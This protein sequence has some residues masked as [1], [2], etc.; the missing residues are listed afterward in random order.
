MRAIP[1]IIRSVSGRLIVELIGHENID[2]VLDVI[3]VLEEFLDD[4]AEQDLEIG[5]DEDVIDGKPKLQ[6]IDALASAV[7]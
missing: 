4:D 1:E 2:I 6:L 3:D 5:D 7:P